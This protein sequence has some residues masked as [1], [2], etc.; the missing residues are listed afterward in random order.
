MADVQIEFVCEACG[1][2]G[3]TPEVSYEQAIALVRG[4]LEL[5]CPR[6]TRAITALADVNQIAQRMTKHEMESIVRSMREGRVDSSQST[7]PT[8]SQ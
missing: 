4:A 5:P 7:K 6:C 8:G 3:L 1:L 2:R